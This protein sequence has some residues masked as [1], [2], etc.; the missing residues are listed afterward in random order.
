ME[1]KFTGWYDVPLSAKGHEEAA[2]GGELLNDEGFKFDLAYTSYLRRAIKTCSHVL[3]ATDCLW[4]PS[5]HAWQ[6]NERHYG[7][8][9]GLD[10]QETVDKFGKEKVLVWRRSFDVPPP[11]VEKDSEHFPGNDFKYHLVD[12]ALLPTTESLKTTAERVL[13]YWESEIVPQIKAG[14]RVLVAAHGNSL[15]AL[16]MHLDNISQD[17]ITELNIPTATPLCYELD[18][19]MKP[20]PHPDAIAPLTARYIGD[21]AAIRARIEGVK[22]QTK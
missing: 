3:D 20:I 16:V 8:L 5:V 18:D 9:T 4:I 1:N 14:K 19:D 11:A 22:N 7:A 2:E 17:E 21:V 15:R 6:L 13:P 10:K 12:P